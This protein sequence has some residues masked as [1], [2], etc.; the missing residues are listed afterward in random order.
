MPFSVS[1]L[2]KMKVKI[3]TAQVDQCDSLRL[4]FR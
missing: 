2:S 3:V 4:K 1:E